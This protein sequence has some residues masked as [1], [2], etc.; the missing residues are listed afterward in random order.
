MITKYKILALIILFTT[1]GF[2]R[3]SNSFNT[4]NSFFKLNKFSS[5]NIII[6]SIEKVENDNIK[7]KRR[8]K[9]R[10]KAPNRMPRRG[11]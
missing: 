11:K 2:P 10:K 6:E 9:R 5:Q 7:W 3:T 1:I 4:I 8:H